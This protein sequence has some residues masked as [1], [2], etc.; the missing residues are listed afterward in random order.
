MLPSERRRH[1]RIQPSADLPARVSLLRDGAAVESFDAH[2]V[3]LGGLALFTAGSL[4]TAQ[5][6]AELA[7]RIDLGRYGS[8]DVR[9]VVRHRSLSEMGITGIELLEPGSEV[10][11]ALRRYV[12]ELMER[13]A[14]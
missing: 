9:A 11:T 3:S 10:T 13:G 4:R 7:L 2:D 8:H 6:G 5:P 14:L 1:L 12:A